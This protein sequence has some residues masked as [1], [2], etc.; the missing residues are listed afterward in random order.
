LGHALKVLEWMIEMSISTIVNVNDMQ[1]GFKPGKGTTDAIFI[2]CQQQS[3]WPKKQYFW[4]ALSNLED[5]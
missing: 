5:I 3:S 4:M 1:F 2:V